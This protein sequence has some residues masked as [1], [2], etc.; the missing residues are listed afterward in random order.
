MMPA[1]P[2]FSLLWQRARAAARRLGALALC[3]PALCMTAGCA[4][5]PPTVAQ[6]PGPPRLALNGHLFHAEAHGPAGAPVL[7]VLHGGPGADYRYLLGLA[8]LSDRYRVVFYD[9]LGSGLSQRVNAEQISIES[10]VADLHA[11]VSH[12]GQGRPVHL[13]GHSWGAMLATAYA[14]A[15]PAQ[16][17]SLVLAEPG[18]LDPDTLAGL[19]RGGWPGWRVVAGFSQAW[20]MKWFVATGGDAFARDDWFMGQV[21]PLT[22]GEAT[23]CAGAPAPMALWRAGSPAFQATIGRLMDDPAWGR[24]LDFTRGLPAYRRPVLF[25]R[26][27]CN[28]AQGED[29]QRRMMGRFHA[30]SHAR[31]A[32]VAEAGHFM[33]NDQPQASLALVRSFL[34]EQPR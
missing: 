4:R 23:R 28:Q 16:V 20:V 17:A 34:D 22:Q 11:F 7:L 9:Q 24:T 2:T 3:L 15:H 14:S 1:S 10:F 5:V 6:D 27:A 31:L 33:F 18:F 30:D 32:T 8:A 12:F 29:H 21:L 25:I 26:G 19:P 13:L